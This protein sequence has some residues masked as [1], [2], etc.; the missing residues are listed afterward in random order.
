M[1]Y[2]VYD[3]ARFDKELWCGYC[4]FYKFLS[5]ISMKYNT[6]MANDII[7]DAVVKAL[8]KDGW[9]IVKERF[10]IEC[11]EVEVY[12]DLLTQRKSTTAEDDPP[13]IIIEIKSFVSRSF[14]KELQHALGQYSFYS[15]MIELAGLEYDLYLAISKPVY[16]DYFLRP[17]TSQI[18]KR[19]QVKLLIVDIDEEEI[20]QWIQ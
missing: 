11:G 2:S 5:N 10:K 8:D 17:V 16:K 13:K 12:A 9:R 4:S 20:V 7:H 19:R 15:D 6:S 1:N 18:V 3:F 14:I